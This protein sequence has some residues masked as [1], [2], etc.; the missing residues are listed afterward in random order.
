MVDEQNNTAA[1][2]A[3]VAIP[4]VVLSD[5]LLALGNCVR[6]LQSHAPRP[7]VVDSA[8]MDHAKAVLIQGAAA[9]RLSE[10][11]RDDPVL[12]LLAVLVASEAAEKQNSADISDWRE[13]IARIGDA[14]RAA[15]PPW[16][17]R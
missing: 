10:P 14:C 1:P 17:A 13:T 12:T 2:A 15:L 16:D 11:P 5:L 9:L 8:V 7:G 4:R 3:S 6:R